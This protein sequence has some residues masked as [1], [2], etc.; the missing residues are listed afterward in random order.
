M[1]DF[2]DA[3][4]GVLVP[5][6]LIAVWDASGLQA[7]CDFL[8]GIACK[9]ELI[10][11]ADAFGLRGIRGDEAVLY[12]VSVE[13]TSVLPLSE[14]LLKFHSV[15]EFKGTG[16]R[17]DQYAGYGKFELMLIKISKWL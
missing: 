8:Q 13:G 6:C 11:L 15:F 5:A 17:I 3:V 2:Y 12:A 9:V 1:L 14:N 10:N 4:N 16:F 7:F